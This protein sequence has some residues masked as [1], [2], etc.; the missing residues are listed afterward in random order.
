MRVKKGIR[1]RRIKKK[2]QGARKFKV[3][4]SITR[5][6]RVSKKHVVNYLP[7]QIQRAYNQAYDR[8]YDQAFNEGFASG[9][10]DGA[11]F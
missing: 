11:A 10:R 4:K 9:L 8:S 5:R 2:T 3:T 7:G 1:L 6:K